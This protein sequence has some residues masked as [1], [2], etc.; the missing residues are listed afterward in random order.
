MSNLSDKVAVITGAAGNLGTAVANTFAAAGA[1]TVLVDRVQAQL[2]QAFAAN[3]DRLL[4]G[5]VD[6]TAEESVRAMA[7]T[8]LEKF[9]RIDVLAHT[10]GG[11]RGGKTVHEEDLSTWDA[12]MAI[13]LRTTLLACR[14][15]IPT[16]LKQGGGSIVVVSA[17]AALKSPAGLAAYSASKAGVLKLTE[18]LA[19]EVKASGVRVNA[20]LPGTIDTPQ[21]RQSMPD[22]DFSKWVKPELIANVIA[23]LAADASQAVNGVALP[24]FGRG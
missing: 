21:N 10:V 15:V 1:R 4:L 2:A 3:E 13:N 22:A 24:V 5:G 12:M 11:F 18:S 23:F 17:G 8:T 7:A 6:L 16:M 14:A 19:A 20:V 9:G